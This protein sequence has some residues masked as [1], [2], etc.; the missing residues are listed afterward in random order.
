MAKKKRYYDSGYM[1]KND[2]SKVANMPTEVMQKM[3]PANPSYYPSTYIDDSIDGIDKLAK[4]MANNP[5]LV[6]GMVE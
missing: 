3:Y 1:I 4:K 2:S 6:K 5:D